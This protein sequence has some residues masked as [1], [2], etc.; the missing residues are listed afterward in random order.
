[1]DKYEKKETNRIKLKIKI[2]LKLKKVNNL[3][4][5]KI[6]FN[7]FKFFFNRLFIK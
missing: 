2:L 3:S 4:F 5:S 1:M 7:L 6:K